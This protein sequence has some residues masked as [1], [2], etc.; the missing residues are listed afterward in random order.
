M[1]VRCV[2]RRKLS[3]IRNCLRTAIFT[4]VHLS[5]SVVVN[6]ERGAVW[7]SWN[8]QTR[9]TFRALCQACAC[10][11]FSSCVAPV[12]ITWGDNTVTRVVCAPG[13]LECCGHMAEG[14]RM[15]MSG[16][17][18]CFEDAWAVTRLRCCVGAWLCQWL[19]WRWWPPMWGD[20]IHAF[21]YFLI[22]CQQKN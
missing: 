17:G 14:K 22:Q 9:S 12:A 1:S 19:R 6:R 21:H 4:E 7:S 16:Y 11:A 10:A 18:L 15:T 3:P 8:A 13:S 5:A 20:K 2:V